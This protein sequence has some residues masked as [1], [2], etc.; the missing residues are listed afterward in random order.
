MEF[1]KVIF[2]MSVKSKGFDTELS[3]STYSDGRLCSDLPDEIHGYA[4]V[5]AIPSEWSD[6]MAT[7]SPKLLESYSDDDKYALY[8]LL[9]R[10]Y[11]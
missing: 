2:L 7:N 8:V 6:T 5:I 3:K 9:E 4:L 10:K 1:V 11:R